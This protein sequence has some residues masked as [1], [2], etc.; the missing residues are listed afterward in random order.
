MPNNDSALEN[1]V[2]P[3]LEVALALL[4]KAEQDLVAVQKW[5]NDADISDAI[6]GFHTQQAMEK[7][8]KAVLS[9]RKV[10]YPR[11]HNL[12]LL[13]DILKNRDIQ[14]PAEFSQIDIFNRFAVEWRYDLFPSTSETVFDREIVYELAHRL[15][16]WAKELVNQTSPTDTSNHG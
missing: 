9:L 11:T 10:D 4:A 6:I 15:W 8:I 13:I 7:S 16:V 5:S 2:L 3:E 12:R 1:G 14:V